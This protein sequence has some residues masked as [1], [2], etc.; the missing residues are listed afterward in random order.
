MP[1]PKKPE[2]TQFNYIHSASFPEL[3][4]KLGISLFV[5]TYQAGKLMV[6]RAEQGCLNTL[7]RNFELLMGLA[8]SPQQLAIG[9]RRQIWFLPNIPGIAGKVDPPNQYE[10]CFVPR[11]SQVTG[12]IRIHELAWVGEELWFVNTRFSCLCT[13]SPEYN[14]VPRWQ[15]RFISQLKAE[16][17]CHLNGL[18]VVDGQPKYVTVLGETDLPQGWR[19]NKANG[20]CL[21]DVPSGEIVAQG[22][23]MPHSPRVYAG[24]LWLLDSGRGRLVVVDP[25]TGNSTT[26]AELPGFTRGLTFCDRYGF[27]ALSQIRE[28]KTFGGLPIEESNEE[29]QCAIWVVDIHTGKRVAFLQFQAGCTEL[30]DVQILPNCRQPTVVGFQKPTINNIFIF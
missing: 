14:F 22:F 17:R 27:V 19:E 15:P 10:A 21:I 25:Q 30:F 11:W 16:D 2:S 6:V 13:V 26:V 20:G 8:L 12:D 28:K 18:A 4:E 9:T 3:L 5:S 29:L 7:L 1:P 24:K 23:S